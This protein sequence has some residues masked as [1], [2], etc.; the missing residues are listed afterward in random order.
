[1][2]LDTQ[3]PQNPKFLALAEDK[4]WRAV[5]VYFASLAWSGAQG[6]AGFVPKGALPMIHATTK[7]AAELVASH[8]WIPAPGGW[9][10]NDWSEYQPTNEEHEERSRKAR[11]AAQ[12]RWSRRKEQHA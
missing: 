11:E 12:I 7:E 10:I 9:D 8:L 1:V 5:A 2:R 6:Q 4:K 3:W